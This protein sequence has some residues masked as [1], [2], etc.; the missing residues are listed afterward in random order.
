M[1]AELQKVQEQ[2]AEMLAMQSNT[3]V[4][5]IDG[6]Q[7]IVDCN[8]GFLKMF[9]LSGKPRGIALAD[10]LVAGVEG[11]EFVPGD[12]ELTC[13]PKSGVHGILMAHR[14]PHESGLLLWCERLQSTN[15]QVVEL[16]AVLNNEFIAIQRELD[17]KNHH[18]KRVQ[19]ELEEKVHQLELAISQIRQLEGIIPICMYCKSI[20]DDKE[21]WHQMEK[22]ISEHSE[23]EFSHGICPVCFEK[24]FGTN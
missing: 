23:A 10:F 11:L 18:L 22:Y 19:N 3:P 17:K 9:S 15:N 21:L 7:R 2:L 24:H 16:M 4:V 6:Q 12:Q 1:I 5:S 8:F 13:N 14:L 20:R